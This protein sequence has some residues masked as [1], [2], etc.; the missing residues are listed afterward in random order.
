[1]VETE[2]GNSCFISLGGQEKGH[3]SYL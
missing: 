3:I 2:E 1:L